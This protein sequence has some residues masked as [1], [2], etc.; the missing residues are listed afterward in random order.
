MDE[1]A[2]RDHEW[3]DCGV[4]IA[5]LYNKDPI[6][7]GAIC[8]AWY[9][10]DDDDQE[11]VHHVMCNGGV[12]P[13]DM[14]VAREFERHAAEIEDKRRAERDKLNE[15]VGELRATSMLAQVTW[16]GMKADATEK[17]QADDGR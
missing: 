7:Y 14:E 13:D 5:D 9:A 6:K 12:Y 1:R 4:A 17:A 3:H 16:D 8:S 11:S 2:M 10:L 15:A